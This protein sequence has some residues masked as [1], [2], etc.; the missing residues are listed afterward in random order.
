M[1]YMTYPLAA[2]RP[3][4]FFAYFRPNDTSISMALRTP[5]RVF[6]FYLVFIETSSSQEGRPAPGVPWEGGMTRSTLY[7]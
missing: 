3:S 6:G 5:G 1:I 4:S 7:A 2:G